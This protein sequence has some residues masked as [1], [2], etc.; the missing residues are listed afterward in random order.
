[1]NNPLK[2]SRDVIVGI[3]CLLTLL[4]FALTNPP[5]RDDS[6]HL[7]DVTIEA[8]FKGGP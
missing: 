5:E 6:N 8:E 3:I 1:M 7:E 4:L 2:L